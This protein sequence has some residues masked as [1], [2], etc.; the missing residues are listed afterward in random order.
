[1]ATDDAGDCVAKIAVG[2]DAI[3]LAGRDERGDRRPVLAV[4]L[5]EQSIV[6]RQARL[7]SRPGK[8]PVCSPPSI[9]IVPLTI[10]VPMPAGYWCGSS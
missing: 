2:A 7:A 10:T 1:M 4:G 9:T 5:G 8:A 6:A 3:E